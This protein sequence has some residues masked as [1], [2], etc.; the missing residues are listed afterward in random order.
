M[1]SMAKGTGRASTISRRAGVQPG[2]LNPRLHAMDV[3]VR[4]ASFSLR[5]R[6]LLAYP[7]AL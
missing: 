2:S 7:V 4:L 6:A 3:H 1:V 5:P